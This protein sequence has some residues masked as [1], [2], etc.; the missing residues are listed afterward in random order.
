[1][2]YAD[3]NVPVKGDK[4]QRQLDGKIGTAVVVQLNAPNF[5]GHDVINF[6]PDDGTIGVSMSLAAEYVLLARV[7]G[8]VERDSKVPNRHDRQD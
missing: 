2:S 8:N 6:R 1:M 7:D 4:I 3:G 5:P